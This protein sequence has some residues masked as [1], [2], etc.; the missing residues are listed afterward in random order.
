VELVVVPGP[1]DFLVGELDQALQLPEVAALEERVR[2]HRAERRRQRHREAEVDAVV[3]QPVH[4]VDERDVGLGDRLVEPVLLEEVL[5]LRMPD[6][7][8]VR[9]EDQREVAL[10]LLMHGGTFGWTMNGER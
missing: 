10:G 9:V 6:E 3:E 1:L 7:G 4:H 2:E 5:V 8:E